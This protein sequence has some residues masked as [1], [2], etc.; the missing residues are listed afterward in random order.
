MVEISEQ[1]PGLHI[2][3]NFISK[4]EESQLIKEIYK[5]EWNT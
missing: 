5:N 4:E 1:I 3:P 2:I